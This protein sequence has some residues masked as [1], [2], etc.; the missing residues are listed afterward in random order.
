MNDLPDPIP[1]A[2]LLRDG[3]RCDRTVTRWKEF[4]AFHQ[5]NPWVYARLEAICFE[6]RRKG[7]TRYS[8]RTLIAVLRF[9]QD[10]QT[11]GSPAPTA[12]GDDEREV[13]LNDHH[14]AYYA[15]ILIEAHPE[16]WD[17]FELRAADG[18]PVCL[19]PADALFAQLRLL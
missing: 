17:F 5:A 2:E 15:R 19:A 8:T 10:M 13:K 6:L 14:T 4:L 1:V 7:F 16:L 18:D 9:E 12:V 3:A 11:T